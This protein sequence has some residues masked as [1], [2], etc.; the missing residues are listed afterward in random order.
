MI[1]QGQISQDWSLA[2]S[3]FPIC[4]FALKFK[5][6]TIGDLYNQSGKYVPLDLK[7]CEARVHVR[8]YNG[9]GFLS[10]RLIL[11]GMLKGMSVQ[12]RS[13]SCH[14]NTGVPVNDVLHI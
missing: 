11:Q 12:E 6:L 14:A 7:L 4:A 13:L 5:H 1:K 3:L 2:H 10:W 9:D 8:F